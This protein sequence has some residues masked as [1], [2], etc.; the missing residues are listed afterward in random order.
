MIKNKLQACLLL[1]ITA[2]NVSASTPTI[3]N[4]T[5]ENGSLGDA[6]PTLRD[7]CLTQQNNDMNTGHLYLALPFAV[8]Y[9]NA[10]KCTAASSNVDG[11]CKNAANTI[12]GGMTMAFHLNMTTLHKVRNAVPAG[13]NA[14]CPCSNTPQ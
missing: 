11:N 9:Y 12:A 6:S 10:L 8:A 1:L 5:A 14:G 7:F 2:A 13:S 3:A 4:C